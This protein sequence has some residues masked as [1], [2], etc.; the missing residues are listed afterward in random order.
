MQNAL[1]RKSNRKIQLNKKNRALWYFLIAMFRVPIPH[2]LCSCQY[3]VIYVIR[4]FIQSTN[5][6]IIYFA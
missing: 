4:F 6:I 5:S 1:K 3:L 2:N